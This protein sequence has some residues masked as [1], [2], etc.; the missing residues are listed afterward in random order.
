MPPVQSSPLQ[1]SFHRAREWASLAAT[2]DRVNADAGRLPFLESAFLTPLLEHFGQGDETVAFGRRGERPVAAALLRRAGPAQV[3]T[4][5]PSQ[6]PLGPWLVARGEDAAAAAHGLVKQMPGVVLGLGLT[7]LDPHVLPRPAAGPRDDTV[8]YIQTGWVDVAGTFDAYWEARGKNLR[9]NMRKQRNKLEAD[10]VTLSFDTI[11]DAHEVP[12]AIADYGRLET[13]G[14]KAGMGTAVHP[15]NAQGRF[16]AAMLGNFCAV[17]RGRIWRL[18]FGD[19]IVAMDLCIEAGDTLV[20][21]KTAF[22][23]EYR[24]VSPAFLMRQDAF[25]QVF[26]QGRLRRIEFYGRM[27]EWHTRWTEQSRTLYHANV[28]RWSLVPQLRRQWQRLAARHRDVP[29]PVDAAQSVPSP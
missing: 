5:Q 14:W 9:A 29:A 23:P 10:G 6:L 15:D 2:W 21:L 8:D 1:W 13:A 18:K 16:Y 26:D 7:Q 27:M 17:G 20:I 3:Q 4:F 28:Y 19:K 22:D 11:T 12:A 24:V 25:R